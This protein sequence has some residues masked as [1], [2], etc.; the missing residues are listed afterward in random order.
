MV[1]VVAAAIS[2]ALAVTGLAS[3]A[4]KPAAGAK[5][6]AAAGAQTVNATIKV[7]DKFDGGN[8]VFNAGGALGSGDQ[9]ENQ[10]ALFDLAAGATISNVIIGSNGADGIHC[11]GSCT[12]LNIVWQDVGEDAATFRGTNATVLVDGGSATSATDKVF[13]DN[14]GAGG[15]VTIRNF[16]VSNFGKLYRSCGNCKLQ[17]ART[18]SISNITATAP[19]KTLVGANS[20]LGDRVT[21][22]NVKISGKGAAKVHT[23]DL[24]KGNNTGK[25]PTKVATAPDGVT[26]K[27]SGVTTT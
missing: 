23:C 20:N 18:V 25:E 15:S 4:T 14:R 27:A 3:A 9:A 21:V 5:K 24:F 26:C 11:A 10:K 13:Q 1:G 12:L 6:K 22:S 16:A 17:A 7:T 2:A 19:G 8:K